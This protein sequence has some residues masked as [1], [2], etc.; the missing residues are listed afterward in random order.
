M[1]NSRLDNIRMVDPV[2]T[3][4]AQGY[5]NSTMVSEHLLPKVPVSK[6]KGKIPVFGKEAFVIRDTYRAIRAQSNR[7][8][9]SD[10][11]LQSFE[12]QE[13]DIEIAIDY[14]EEEESPDFAKYE[15][16]I[17]K[18]LVDILALG[19][20]KE[21]ADYV[22]NPDNFVDSL[23]LGINSENAWNDSSLSSIN[24]IT[25][26]NQG[27]VEIRKRISKYPNTMIIGDS[28]Y[29]TLINHIKVTDRITYSG[30]TKVDT[31]ILSEILSIPNIFVGKA[32][33]SN[34]GTNFNDVWN[35][36]IIIAYVDNN[37]AKN[38]SEFNPS[39]GYIFQREGKPEIDTYY[40]NGGKIKVIRNTDNYCMKITAPDAAFLIYNINNSNN[41]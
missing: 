5:S 37:E 21:V 35:D 8:S 27:M 40:E 41:S 16:R 24:P 4:I 19:R 13:K 6:L 32:I 2:L 23:K 3:T 20:E 9:P 33:Y 38:R 34:D 15:Q 18:E 7:I 31:S 29:R 36:N 10:I 11:T 39:Y 17:T 26:I 30:I 12:T 22:Q 14:I 28:A 25:M 1:S